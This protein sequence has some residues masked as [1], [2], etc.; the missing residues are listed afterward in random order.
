MLYKYIVL[1]SE[2]SSFYSKIWQVDFKAGGPIQYYYD[3]RNYRSVY[4]P[5]PEQ[6]KAFKEF[7]LGQSASRPQEEESIEFCKSIIEQYREQCREQ[8]RIEEELRNF[9][10]EIRS[11]MRFSYVFHRKNFSHVWFNTRKDAQA[12]KDFVLRQPGPHDWNSNEYCKGI[13]DQYSKQYD[14]MN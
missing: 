14:T 10:D 4:F 12:F 6:A 8:C 3:A 2:M 1:Q 5:T 7:V 9:S 13:V 11:I